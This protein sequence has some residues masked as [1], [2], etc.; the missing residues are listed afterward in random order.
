MQLI[1]DN[2]YSKSFCHGL[3]EWADSQSFCH[4]GAKP[5]WERG[6]DSR[7][8]FEDQKMADAILDKIKENLPQENSYGRLSGVDDYLRLFRFDAGFQLFNPEDLTRSR[9]EK[10]F[11]RVLIFLNGSKKQMTLSLDNTSLEIKEGTALLYSNPR[12]FNLE[13]NG[14]LYL[15]MADILYRK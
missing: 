1:F 14:H 3:I 10:I 12:P 15:L 4:L 2:F 11:Y 13:N 7:L 9:K 5:I 6:N 8:V